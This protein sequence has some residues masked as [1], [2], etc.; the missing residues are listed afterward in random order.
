[1]RAG[2]TGA[3][4]SGVLD[5][6]VG[7]HGDSL[8]DWVIADKR[9]ILKLRQARNVQVL[10]GPSEYDIINHPREIGLRFT[11]MGSKK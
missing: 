5:V 9:A 3:L 4:Q 7:N 8:I 10:E 6:A 1:V 11:V 2:C